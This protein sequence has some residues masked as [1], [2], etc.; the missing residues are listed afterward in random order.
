MIAAMRLRRRISPWLNLIAAIVIVLILLSPL[1]WA[2]VTS[3]KTQ[4]QTYASPATLLPPTPNFQ[5][6]AHVIQAQGHALLS[7]LVIALGAALL[8]LIIATPAA[9]ALAHFRFRVTGIVV[10]ALL[11]AQ[12]VPTIVIGTSLYK[13]YTHIGLLNS[14]P[15]LILADS[16]YAVPFAILVLRAFLTGIPTELLEAAAIDGAG[17][18]RRFVRVIIPLSKPGL[19]SV[20]LFAFLFAW[21]DFLF[22]LTLTTTNKIVPITLSIYSYVGVSIENWPSVMAASLF[23]AVPAAVFLVVVQRVVK[24]GLVST[25]LKG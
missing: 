23:A 2:A 12:V 20:T 21:G 4:N 24:G 3:L 9:Y 18:L 14:Y 25:G 19:L 16:T 11:A 6:Y 8:T 10:L 15:G 5:A 22:A 1:Y 7:S 13:T 17:E